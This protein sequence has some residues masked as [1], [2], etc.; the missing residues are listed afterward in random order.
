[1]S[2]PNYELGDR[3]A[4]LREPDT[5]H[6]KL[7]YSSEEEIWSVPVSSDVDD[8]GSNYILVDN[9]GWITPPDGIFIVE[10]TEFTTH[11]GYPIWRIVN[12]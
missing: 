10:L 3:V 9:G 5:D 4:V 2:N 11:D 8:D 7:R 6:R 12:E 1:M